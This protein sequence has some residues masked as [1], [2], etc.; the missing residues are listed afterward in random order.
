MATATEPQRPEP[1][2]PADAAGPPCL[3]CGGSDFA[4]LYAGIHDR[5]GHVGGEWS[6]VRCESC[7]SAQLRP[8]P[9]A[10][11]IAGFYPPVYTFKPEIG[12]SPAQRWLSRLEYALFFRPVYRTQ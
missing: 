4:P 3:Y 6:F 9:Q 5:L 1:A 10:A 11:D 12:A 8:F 7:G 2:C